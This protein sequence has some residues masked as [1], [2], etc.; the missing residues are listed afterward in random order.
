MIRLTKHQILGLH[1]AL[2]REFGGEFGVRDYNLLDLSINSPF[3][4]FDGE[5]VYQGDIKKIVHLAFSLIKNH[6]FVDGNKRIGT[7]V[8]L[9]LLEMNDYKLKYEQDELI[10][11]IMDVA[12]SEKSESDLLTRIKL[13]II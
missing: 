8:M 2:I 6:P 7:H 4:T 12:S 1:E 13:H 9:I 5:Y 11:I 3:Q 10:Q